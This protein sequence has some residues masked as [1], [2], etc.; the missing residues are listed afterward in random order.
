MRT[1]KLCIG[2]MALTQAV[3]A[4][5]TM[6]PLAVSVADAGAGKVGDR[7]SVAHDHHG[8]QQFPELGRN[9]DI[10]N[11]GTALVR[12]DGGWESERPIPRAETAF[13][14]LLTPSTRSRTIVT[15]RLD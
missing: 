9:F 8:G 12:P 1:S 11:G 15:I 3:P 10:G 14:V 6:V 13:T 5:L 7:R 4:P 2:A